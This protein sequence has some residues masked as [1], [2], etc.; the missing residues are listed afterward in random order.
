MELTT[1]GAAVEI[2]DKTRKAVE[3]VRERVRTSKDDELKSSVLSLY[4]D[5]I[6]I[7]AIMLR[8]IE[9]NERLRQ[10]I[11]GATDKPKPEAREV[12][13]TI[14]YY[15]GQDGPYCQ[16]CYDKD[17]ELRKLTPKQRY[18]GGFGRKCETCNKIFIEEQ[19]P[20]RQAQVR[21]CWS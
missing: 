3:Y 18:G 6:S 15:M 21:N 7:R 16:P 13:M 14:Y 5:F 9:E 10:T 2:V 19:A 20:P 1:V 11:S 8:L 4:D 17:K 12:G